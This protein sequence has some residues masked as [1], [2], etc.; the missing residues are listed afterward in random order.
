MDSNNRFGFQQFPIHKFP[1]R[2]KSDT[3]SYVVKLWF[4]KFVGW[5]SGLSALKKYD[6]RS[7]PRASASVP[8]WIVD[9]GGQAG[10]I[11]L[12]I[13]LRTCRPLTHPT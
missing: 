11:D 8:S 12:G 10:Q 2:A 3:V 13:L 1:V 9:F 4:A 7:R 5:V 6:N